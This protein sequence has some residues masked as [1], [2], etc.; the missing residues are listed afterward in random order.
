MPRAGGTS[1]RIL[2]P[3]PFDIS[4]SS[5]Y[6]HEICFVVE[7][8][9]KTF[10]AQFEK[11]LV[12]LPHARHVRLEKNGSFNV[13]WVMS[14]RQALLL[15]KYLKTFPELSRQ[16]SVGLKGYSG[17][18]SWELKGKGNHS[19]RWW[20]K[21]QLMGVLNVTPDSFSDGGRHLNPQIAVER[22]LQMQEEG[23]DWVDIGGESTRPGAGSVSAS[24]E[25]KRILPVVK[26]CAKALRIPVS[27]DTYKSV[28]AAAAVGEG[29]QMV[30]DIGALKFDPRMG[31]TLARL[32]VPVVLM[33]M[34]GKPRT[35]QKN[36][37]YE[38]LMDELVAFFGASLDYA[39]ECGIPRD[40]LLIDPGFG[41]G[42]TPWH[43]VEMT[44]RLWELKVLNR[45]IVMGPSRKSTLGFLTGG[46]PPE[47]RVEA[48]GAVVT[49]AILKG[50][51]MVRVHDVK[52]MARVVKIADAI[53]Y[54]RG[55]TT[56]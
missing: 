11:Y 46:A 29:A 27:V 4:R 52:A 55:L 39:G 15:P 32:K 21:T 18:D 31:K 9:S 54:D 25:K 1:F 19:F 5:S 6:P 17:N 2:H 20:K 10:A 49:A 22:A 12:D 3:D 7:F 40:R 43:N 45:P 53:R 48:T 16:M 36:P 8:S 41:F 28:V 24:E 38:D 13:L 56:P 47:D 51:D 37:S 23:A 35:M 33:H 42:K 44:R 50:A 34:Q 14:L 26:A 30:N